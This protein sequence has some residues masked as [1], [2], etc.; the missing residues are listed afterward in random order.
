MNKRMPE[1]KN[2]RQLNKDRKYKAIKKGREAI[3]IKILKDQSL[4][5]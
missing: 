4:C 1:R 2:D 3:L 5:F